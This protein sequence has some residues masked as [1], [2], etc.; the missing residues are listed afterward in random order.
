MNECNELSFIAFLGLVGFNFY[1]T[2]ASLLF[3]SLSSH[4]HFLFVGEIKSILHIVTSLVML[5]YTTLQ[6]TPKLQSQPIT[7]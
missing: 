1:N 5:Y 2:F 6:C 7:I 3:L 4:S